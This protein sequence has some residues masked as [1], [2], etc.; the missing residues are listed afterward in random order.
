MITTGTP[1]HSKICERCGCIE[2]SGC[3]LRWYWDEGWDLHLL[4]EQCAKEINKEI[5]DERT[6]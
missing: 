6:E 2:N 4:C 3:I 5:S 1:Y